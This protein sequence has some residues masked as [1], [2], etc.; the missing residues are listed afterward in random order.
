MDSNFRYRG[1][2]AVNF[3]GIPGIAGYPDAQT[4]DAFFLPHSSLRPRPHPRLSFLGGRRGDQRPEG[5]SGFKRSVPQWGDAGTRVY[6][7]LAG[8]P[9]LCC[10]G[11]KRRELLQCV[12]GGGDLPNRDLECRSSAGRSRP[13]GVSLRLARI[14]GIDAR[15]I[16]GSASRAEDLVRMFGYGFSER[17]LDWLVKEEQAASRSTMC[18]MA[19]SARW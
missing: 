17:E 9:R 14:Y 4:I 16:L 3:R 15:R 11:E 2:K 5:G 1:T 10:P 8:G 12:L 6:A 18:W 7:T 13:I 19:L